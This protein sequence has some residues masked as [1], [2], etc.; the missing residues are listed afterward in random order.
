MRAAVGAAVSRELK[1]MRFGDNMRQVAVTE[2][3]KVEVQ[4]KLGWQVNTYAVGDLVDLLV[5][6]GGND[7]DL[8]TARLALH[9]VRHGL[10]VGGTL[11][12]HSDDREARVDQ[13]DGAVLHLAG[14]VGLGVQVADLFELERA[15]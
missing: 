2:G 8:G 12:G 3:D 1:V 4:M 13:R 6:L 10:V 14:G 15:S 11:G 5:A 7:D 9:E